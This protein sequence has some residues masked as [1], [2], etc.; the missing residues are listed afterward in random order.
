MP[1]PLLGALALCLLLL[2][3]CA[4]PGWA[5]PDTFAARAEALTRWVAEDYLPPGAGGKLSVPQAARGVPDPQKYIWPKVMAR[6]AQNSKDA[7]SRAALAQFWDKGGDPAPHAASFYHFAAY[8][9]ARLLFAFPEAVA[10]HREAILRQALRE[11]QLF[12]ADGTENHIA[13]WR[14]S[15]YLFAQEA[16]SVERRDE[17]KAWIDGY[18]ARLYENGQGEWDSSTYHTFDIASWLNLYDYAKD[19][20]VKATARRVVDFFAAGLALKYTHGALAGAEKRGF[21]A[22]STTAIAAYTGWLWFGDT[23]RP[24]GEN[25]FSQ[26]AIYTLI[27]AL[28]G[29]R[30]SPAV[31]A[32]AR[33]GEWRAAEEYHNSKPS[34]A[35]TVPSQTRETLYITPHYSVGVSYSPIGGWGG[36]DTQ[37]TLWKW[38]ARGDARRGSAAVLGGAG[39]SYALRHKYLGEGRGPWDQVAHHKDMVLQMTRVPENAAELTAQAQALFDRWRE[40]GN[41]AKVSWADPSDAPW[42]YFQFPET[43]ALTER[44]GILFLD[45]GSAFVAAR[46]LNGTYSWVTGGMQKGIRVAQTNGEKGQLLGFAYEFGDRAAD[47]GFDAFQRAILAKS[48]L[49]TARLGRNVVTYTNRRGE[50]LTAQF[51]VSGSY[52]EPEYDWGPQ[53]AW[54][55]GEGHGRIPRVWIDGAERDLTRRWP[56]Y[57]GPRLTLKDG[58]LSVRQPK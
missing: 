9:L 30:P 25:F 55:S 13:M 33:K 6:L 5:T 36:G 27:P 28:S 34:Y 31:V 40:Q 11:E 58:V 2:S 53:P 43:T 49:D 38:V 29:Y 4:V 20:A 46:P 22:A 32:L 51:G 41:R 24:P 21:S 23:P 52:V 7:W 14:T 3:L 16:G 45:G 56:V 12:R 19:P 47:G 35:M 37:E 54:P 17:M 26:S 57:S 8:G 44:E 18:A 39:A 50:T 15:G 1:Y 42:A 48:R 10:P